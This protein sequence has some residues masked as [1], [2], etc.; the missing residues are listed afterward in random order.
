MPIPIWAN[1]AWVRASKSNETSKERT[2]TVVR[3]KTFSCPPPP[4]VEWGPR[5]G[6][7]GASIYFNP[8]TLGDSQNS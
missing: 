3:I 6:V 4:V 1:P 2:A 5:G 8:L 7:G